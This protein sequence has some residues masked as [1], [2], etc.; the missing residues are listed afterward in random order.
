MSSSV[1]G[2]IVPETSLSNDLAK[3]FSFAVLTY[4]PGPK[5]LLSNLKL[6]PD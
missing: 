5:I 4:G 1:K 2:A 3:S 6:M